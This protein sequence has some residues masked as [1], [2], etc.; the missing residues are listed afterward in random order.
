M[1]PDRSSPFILTAVSCSLDMWIN[2]MELL[3]ICM[4]REG[5]LINTPKFLIVGI[6]WF[7]CVYLRI[8]AL[9]NLCPGRSSCLSWYISHLSFF[10]SS[11]C[12]SP[13]FFLL[14]QFARAAM[15]RYD[16]LS[17]LNNITLFTC[18]SRGSESKIR[19]SAGF[20][21]SECPSVACRWLPSRVFTW[22]S[23][24]CILSPFLH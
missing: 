15:M 22:S 8:A 21:S 11:P 9:L 16:R 1:Y 12:I 7:L 14:C 13:L 4:Q 17:D 5:Q 19:V 2:I 18:S 24:V 6:Y 20:I 23:S 10:L 3:F